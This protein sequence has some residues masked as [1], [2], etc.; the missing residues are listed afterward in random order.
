LESL[1]ADELPVQRA[2]G[3]LLWRMQE[4][5]RLEGMVVKEG[6]GWLGLLCKV[7]CK[8]LALWLFSF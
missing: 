4:G 2:Q 3:L 7:K 6:T 8:V 1:P 5:Q